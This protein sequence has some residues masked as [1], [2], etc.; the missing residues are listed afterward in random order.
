MS[1]IEYGIPMPESKARHGKYMAPLRELVLLSEGASCYF[2]INPKTEASL[3]NS[4][5]RA[6]RLV[7]SERL[8]LF[9]VKE[10]GKTRFRI[11]KI[12]PDS[13]YWK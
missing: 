11:W 2:D 7:D 5:N 4:L 9:K 13:E 1:E 12:E 8:H 6:I 10:D 3:R